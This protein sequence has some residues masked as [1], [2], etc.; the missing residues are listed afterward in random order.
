M[1]EQ[2]IKNRL[3]QNYEEQLNLIKQSL[4]QGA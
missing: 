3:E 4:S 1:K 2:G